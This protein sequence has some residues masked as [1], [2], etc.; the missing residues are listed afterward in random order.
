MQRINLL[1]SGV[2]G[3]IFIL[4]GIIWYLLPYPL[5]ELT[6][7]EKMVVDNLFEKTKTQCISRYI[8]DVPESFNNQ[9]KD[10]IYIDNFKIESQFIYPPS[11]KQR[12]ELREAELR[13][14]KTSAENA[15]M[16]KEV[17]QL[18]DGKGVIFDRNKPATDDAYRVLEAHIYLNHIAFI[19]TT[20][21]RDFSDKKYTK[22]K[23]EYL[24][25]GG[26]EFLSNQKPSRLVAMR[27]LISRLSGRLDDEIPT[28][29]GTCIPNGFILDDTEKHQQQVT[30]LYEN[31]DFFLSLEFDN[32]Y[33]GSSDT[34]LN[35]DNE[36]IPMLYQQGYQT[37]K[38]GDLTPNGIP[39]QEWLVAKKQEVYSDTE[40]RRIPNLPYYDFQFF[41]NEATATNTIPKLNIGMHNQDKF[42]SYSGAQMVEIWDRIVGSLRYKPNAF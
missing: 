40:N 33:L 16:L 21:I 32:R 36:I 1:V 18:P 23:A 5:P 34:L 3:V 10:N 22:R 41:A 17:I 27:S 35:R 31:A 37:I 13:E 15:P 39:S 12:I 20:D 26:S 7:K 2:L 11:F 38:K 6:D 42:T 24:A 9:L 4:A 28:E 8:I 25:R 29:K 30:I 19:I 14:W